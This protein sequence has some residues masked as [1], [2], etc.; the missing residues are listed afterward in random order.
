MPQDTCNF[1]EDDAAVFCCCKKCVPILPLWP[2]FSYLPHQHVGISWLMKREK[3]PGVKGG[4]L[5]DEMGL[6]KTIQMISLIAFGGGKTNLLIAP[7]AVLQQWKKVAKKSGITIMIPSSSPWGTWE[8]EGSVTTGPSLY[9][10]GYEAALR[11]PRLLEQTWDRL[12]YDEAHRIANGNSGT[13]LALKVKATN[14]WLL[15]GTPVVNRLRDLINLF[16]ILGVEKIPSSLKGM[17]PMIKKFVMVRTMDQLRATLSDAPLAPIHVTKQ[18]DFLTE[19]EDKFY[20]DKTDIIAKRL[21]R[22]QGR[23]STL[24]RLKLIMRLRQVSL[25]PQIY[26]EA[27]KRQLGKSWDMPDWLG[28]SSKFEAIRQTVME[29]AS[30]KWIIFCHFRH[31]MN[32]LEEMLR[33]EN[34]V[35]LVQQYHGGLTSHQKEEVIE[36]SFMPLMKGKQE[37]LL[38]QLQSG[39][40]GL[41][42]QHFDRIIFSGP[43]WTKALMDQAVG[44]AVRIGQKK[45]VIVYHLH[46]KAEDDE[47]LNID[48]FMFEK[49]ESKGGLCKEVLEIAMKPADLNT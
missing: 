20:K 42:L 29:G 40:T 31:E 12:I 10:I 49:A 30:H 11:K 19:A 4:I 33:E 32:M 44:R 1:E 45:Q 25:H 8:P 38:V 34:D 18:I 24:E 41:N 15:T 39:G 2:G 48:H 5:C 16:K 22:L 43:W 28:T 27:R 26:N 37:I 21:N 46:L 17:E 3:R 47:N 7:V 23:G 13:E 6:G 14:K 35:E 36:R 9:C